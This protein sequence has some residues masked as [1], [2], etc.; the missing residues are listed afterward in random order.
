MLKCKNGFVKRI[1]IKYKIYTIKTIDIRSPGNLFV[2]K[3]RPRISTHK[4]K[5]T[6]TPRNCYP[7]INQLESVAGKSHLHVK[8][9]GP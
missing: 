6:Q 1:Q 9:E 5:N 7:N 3:G 2:D 8:E 4:Q